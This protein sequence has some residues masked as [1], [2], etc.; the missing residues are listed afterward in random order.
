[1]TWML[2]L[3]A[4][5]TTAPSFAATPSVATIDASA[6]ASGSRKDIAVRV[7]HALFVTEWPAQVQRISA[8]WIDSWSSAYAFRG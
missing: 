7:G 1:M 8:E 4:L 3:A 2:L 5:I 6:R